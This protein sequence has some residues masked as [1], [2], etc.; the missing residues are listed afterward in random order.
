MSKIYV[1]GLILHS[2][3]AETVD[4]ASKIFQFPYKEA[5]CIISVTATAG[6]TE[7][8]DVTLEEWDEVS[9]TYFELLAFTQVTGETFERVLL[10]E[11]SL[12]PFGSS[13]R[14]VWDI[15]GVG[16]TFTFSL[17]MHGKD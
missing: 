14:A 9:N 13:I 8:L 12:A 17:S 1:P 15:E 7:T 6:A 3:S 11:D 2:S 10:N 16:A 5:V 4:G